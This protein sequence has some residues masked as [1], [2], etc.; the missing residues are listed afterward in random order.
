MRILIIE[1]EKRTAN[2][3]KRTIFEVLPAAEILGIAGSVEEG[4]EMLEKEEMIDLVF[5]DI[6]L[7]DGLSFEIF[8]AVDKSIPVIFCTAFDQFALQAFQ[9]YGI[10]YILKP[11]DTKSVTRALDKFR[12]LRK[13]PQQT[14][15]N[16][17]AEAI[18]QQLYPQQKTTSILIHQGEKLIPLPVEEVAL[19]FIKDEILSALTFDQ[20]RYFVDQKLDSLELA[21]S[22]AF[23]RANRQHL[24]HRKAIKDV[25][26][27]YHRKLQVNL[28]IPFDGQILVGKLKVTAFKEWLS[29]V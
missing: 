21:L 4:I 18:R 11:F 26:Q 22:P 20:K 6:Q 29:T 14:D 28:T 2:D 10:D 17:I 15:F 16:V 13:G 7:S 9:T 24:V 12:D 1:D 23:F 19:F 8:Q 5:S 27:Y 3:L 25:S